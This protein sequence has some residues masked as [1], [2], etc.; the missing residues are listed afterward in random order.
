M[1]LLSIIGKQRLIMPPILKKIIGFILL[2]VT[3][4]FIAI[5]VPFYI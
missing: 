4:G 3:V 5:Q 1:A 2:A